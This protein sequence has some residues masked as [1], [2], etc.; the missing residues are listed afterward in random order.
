MIHTKLHIVEQII[1]RRDFEY[2]VETVGR[3]QSIDECEAIVA[4]M[5]TAP[6]YCVDIEVVKLLQRAD[7][8]NTLKALIEAGIARL[9]FNPMVLEFSPP[10]DLPSRYFCLLTE[11]D[12]KTITSGTA[13]LSRDHHELIIGTDDYEIELLQEGMVLHNMQAEKD[14]SGWASVV[15]LSIAL[16]M[17]NT[18]GIEKEV[19]H[20]DRINKRRAA[21]NDG[22]PP[23][24]R[25]TVVRIGT[26]YD[27]S[28]KA[29]SVGGSGRHMPV[30]LR[31]G[32]VRHQHFG[33]GNEEV[34]LIYIPPCIV[35][36]REED[37]TKPAIPHKTIAV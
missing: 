11:K 33:K 20:T 34:K 25:H 2:V 8:M 12:D 27:R 19:I 17:L 14:A 4:R 30:H 22:R 28:G 15:A 5:L 1:K 9:P 16:L 29:H 7:V 24:P 36:Y 3:K 18:Q 26:I 6:T 35:N 32:H 31:A 37:G 21:H 10:V 23:I 13:R